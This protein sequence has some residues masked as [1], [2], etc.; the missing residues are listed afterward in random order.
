MED[1]D[2]Q[3][4]L[5]KCTKFPKNRAELSKNVNKLK[6]TGNWKVC[7]IKC[8]LVYKNRCHEI[9]LQGSDQSVVFFF[10][11]FSLYLFFSDQ[12]AFSYSQ[13]M[14]CCDSRIQ[15]SGEWAS[16]SMRSDCPVPSK[17]VQL[18]KWAELG[19]MVEIH[20]SQICVS[21][22]FSICLF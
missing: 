10:F 16:H 22:E 11:H 5:Y 9:V 8:S 3:N 21:L 4:P 6:P 2:E 14:S 7:P 15:K 20:R 18:S 13:G 12:T 17:S 1:G 19:L